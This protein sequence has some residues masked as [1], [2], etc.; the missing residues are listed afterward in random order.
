MSRYPLH[1]TSTVYTSPVRSRSYGYLGSRYGYDL[2][3]TVIETPVRTEYRDIVHTNTVERKVDVPVYVD[4]IV[5]KE[6]I[7]EVPVT[8][9][10]E[11][12]VEYP[13]DK[14]VTKTVEV[15][16]YY[17]RYYSGLYDRYGYR[18]GSYYDDYYYGRRSYYDPLLDYPRDYYY[19]SY[20]YRRYY[21]NIA[22]PY[23]YRY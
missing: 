14:V 4:R 1:T 10:V 16:T 23:R 9:V 2:V 6:K 17:P 21:S 5:E 22:F 13:V 19:D 12:V 20:G 7:V 8:K 3:D 18:Y 11:N 15:P